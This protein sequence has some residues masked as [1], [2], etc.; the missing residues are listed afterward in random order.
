MAD[1]KPYFFRYKYKTLDKEY[2]EYIKKS[3]EDCEIRFYRSL[4]SLKKDEKENPENLTPEEKEF[5]RLFRKYLPVIESD[6]VMNKI[7][8]YIENIDFHI[9]QRVKSSE[10]FDYRILVTD[11]F[12]PNKALY[13]QICEEVFDTFSAWD[14]DRK[15]EK[16]TVAK[17]G[18][19]A[20]KKKGFDKEIQYS[21]LKQRLEQIC[22]NE[23]SLVNHLV[24]LFYV[25]KPS[26]NK[27]ILWKI[28]GKQI[29][30][31]MKAKTKSFYFPQKNPNGTLEFLYEKYSIE[32]VIIPKEEEPVD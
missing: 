8:K 28:A 3:E 18:E 23:E 4:D 5:L 9:K 12:S 29:Y 20:E 30:E 21:L 2:K 25:D 31:T 14:R 13:A 15:A 22:S 16:R 27:A 17:I 19:D 7:C 6:C 26:Y 32:R 11:N 10:N 24:Y 1:K